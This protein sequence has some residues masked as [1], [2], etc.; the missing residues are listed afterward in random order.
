MGLIYS[1][2]GPVRNKCG[3]CHLGRQTLFFLEKKLA[4]FLVITVRVSAVGSP[5]KL[6]TF[7]GHRCRFYSFHSFTRLSPIMQKNAAPFV[8]APFCGGT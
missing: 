6:A 7:F 5:E 8:G 3:A 4:T 1:R 2:Q